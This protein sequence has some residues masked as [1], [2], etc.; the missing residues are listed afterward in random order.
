MLAEKNEIFFL[1]TDAPGILISVV[2]TDA[3]AKKIPAR[4]PE[5]NQKQY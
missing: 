2:P 3:R 4:I 1:L 5:I